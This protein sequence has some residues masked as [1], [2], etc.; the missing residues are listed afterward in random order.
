MAKAPAK[1]KPPTADDPAID[2]ET[3]ATISNSPAIQAQIAAFAE[4]TDNLREAAAKKAL[5]ETLTGL[6]LD[7]PAI[8]FIVSEEFGRK[9]SRQP[10]VNEKGVLIRTKRDG[11]TLDLTNIA[12]YR[13]RYGNLV[14][15]DT[16]P[17]E[18]ALQLAAK[19]STDLTAQGQLIK[20]YGPEI[21][22]RLLKTVGGG[23]GEVVKP[24]APKGDAASTNPWARSGPEAEAARLRIIST[25]TRL[26]ASLAKSAGKR[27]DGRDLLPTGATAAAGEIAAAAAAVKA[28]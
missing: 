18:L 26:A 9:R 20:Q 19:A 6:K 2:P 8:K 16:S 22:N 11:D 1:P 3:L 10:V 21:A 7:K 4:E 25:D 17:G 14:P 24:K 27:I 15:G 28:K 13:E 12:Y 5:R 23:L